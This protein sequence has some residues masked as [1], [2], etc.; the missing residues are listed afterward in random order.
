VR[1]GEA[2]I[3]LNSNQIALDVDSDGYVITAA[4]GGV[5][6]GSELSIDGEK[7][8]VEHIEYYPVRGHVFQARLRAV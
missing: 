6:V 2:V 3:Q 4:C 1:G 8:T 5:N 7:F